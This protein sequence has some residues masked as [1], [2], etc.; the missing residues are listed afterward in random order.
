MIITV[1]E[2]TIITIEDLTAIVATYDL[3][4]T[5]ILQ[6]ENEYDLYRTLDRLGVDHG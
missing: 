6:L 5:L 1:S 4:D 3:I 2:K